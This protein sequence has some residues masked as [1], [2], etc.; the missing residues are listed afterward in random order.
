MSATTTNNFRYMRCS[1]S[2]VSGR[3]STARRE[4]E[5]QRFGEVQGRDGSR[6]EVGGPGVP[7]PPS[8][9]SFFPFTLLL[10][11]RLVRG[12]AHAELKNVGRAA[13]EAAT[14]PVGH[15]RD[16]QVLADAH[17]VA[18]ATED[19][20][21]AIGGGRDAIVNRQVGIASA[22]LDEEALGRHRV[23]VRSARHVA[24][25]DPASAF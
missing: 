8:Y 19:T 5:V 1:N 13:R 11:R 6:R 20:E 21:P 9:A 18:Q 24:H 14:E 23:P 4:S 15:R 17:V 10:P 2:N 12:Y 16:R 25:G 7:D 3:C 22:G